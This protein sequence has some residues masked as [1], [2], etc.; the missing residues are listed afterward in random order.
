[1]FHRKCPS[2]SGNTNWAGST[3][4]HQLAVSIFTAIIW[5]SSKSLPGFTLHLYRQRICSSLYKHIHR[6]CSVC[7][8]YTFEVR[9]HKPHVRKFLYISLC[10]NKTFLSYLGN[11]SQVYNSALLL[12]IKS[13]MPFFYPNPVWQTVLIKNCFK[14]PTAK[15]AFTVVYES[16]TLFN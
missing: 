16:S 11:I 13:Q 10:V 3:D 14:V 2:Q 8:I 15:L 7:F 5:F 9:T 4:K 12:L 6:N 1:M